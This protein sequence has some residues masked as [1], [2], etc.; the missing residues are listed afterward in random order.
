MA[1][2]PFWEYYGLVYS[3]FCTAIKPKLEASVIAVFVGIAGAFLLDQL[4]LVPTG[5]IFLRILVAAIPA[6]V[7]LLAYFG[8]HAIRAPWTTHNEIQKDREEEFNEI[9]GGFEAAHEETKH[10]LQTTRLE[11][12]SAINALAEAQSRIGRPEITLHFSEAIPREPVWKEGT[13]IMFDRESE[14]IV[15]NGSG[16]D[17]HDIW[18]KPTT[19]GPFNVQGRIPIDLPSNQ[20]RRIEYIVS[21]EEE[22]GTSWGNLEYRHNLRPLLDAIYAESE[23]EK[24][25]SS[26][27]VYFQL[28]YRDAAGDCFETRFSMSH[29]PSI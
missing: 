23:C 22:N 4:H 3:R 27:M 10:T 24:T 8:V 2:K 26:L 1:D 21:H 12:T 11:L 9:R 19:I 29:H 18:L 5:Q 13:L 25:N 20:E 14:F 7:I 17:A 16:R 6:L 15:R 28:I